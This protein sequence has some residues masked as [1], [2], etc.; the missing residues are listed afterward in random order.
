M[1]FIPKRFFFNARVQ[2]LAFIRGRLTNEYWLTYVTGITKIVLKRIFKEWVK[3][4]LCTLLRRVKTH[5]LA[6][7]LRIWVYAITGKTY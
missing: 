6:C 4:E 1:S 5:K 3:L 2:C 7:D